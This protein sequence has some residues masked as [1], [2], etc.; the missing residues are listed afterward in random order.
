MQGDSL[1]NL[2]S[3]E[4]PRPAPG[5]TVDGH[6][7]AAHHA[8]FRGRARGRP[9]KDDLH[10]GRQDRRGAESRAFGQGRTGAGPCADR[11]GR[12]A[13]LPLRPLDTPGHPVP[14]SAR[15]P[16]LD[17]TM[18][19]TRV[20]HISDRGLIAALNPAI[21]G[22]EA[23]RGAARDPDPMA[24]WTAWRAYLLAHR[25]RRSLQPPEDLADYAAVRD[26]IREAD[27]W[28]AATSSAGGGAH[29]VPG[30]G[31]LLAQPRRLIE[32]RLPLLRMDHAAG[33]GVA[34]RRVT[35]S[36]RAPSWRFSASG[37]GSGTW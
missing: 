16:R 18:L 23:V 26:V 20:K 33:P 28:C 8:L 9:G 27:S 22:L 32:L 24:P 25:D 35:R 31:R 2:F 10:P 4:D 6:P 17:A 30:G 36:T 13:R 34:R 7:A 11:T 19:E 3:S 1:V 15:R 29:P 14:W 21:A 5:G 37:T 12:V